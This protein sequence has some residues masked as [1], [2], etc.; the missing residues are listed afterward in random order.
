M[1]RSGINQYFILAMSLFI[2]GCYDYKQ[3]APEGFEAI[4]PIQENQMRQGCPNLIDTYLITS[5]QEHNRLLKEPIDGKDFSYFVIDALVGGQAYN[6]ALRMDRSQFI[7]KAQDLKNSS[8]EKYFL[9]RESTLLMSKSYSEER[10]TK[11]L[12]YGHV[13]E[14]KGQLHAYGCAD[15]WVMVQQIETSV[16][17]IKTE[18]NYIRQDNIS[19]A[20]N[21]YGDLLIHITS[22]RQKPGRTF[23][24]AGGAGMNLVP[25]FEQWI[26]MRKAPDANL[27]AAWNEADLP[28]AKRPIQKISQCKLPNEIIDFNQRLTQSGL[29]IEQFSIKPVVIEDGA[30]VQPPLQLRFSSNTSGQGEA[31]MQSLKNDPI[32]SD[33]ELMETR[34]HNGRL[35]YLVQVSFKDLETINDESAKAL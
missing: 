2:T 20:R 28:I 16:W 23:W 26:K 5:T 4:I 14:R 10:L 29:L 9:W 15:G 27:T 17:D 6:Y 34:Y 12:Q 31:T 19:L 22:Y 30:C 8:Q 1:K 35:H 18:S 32:V 7:H 11:T 21:Q 24:A 25:M 13:Y 33:I 3:K